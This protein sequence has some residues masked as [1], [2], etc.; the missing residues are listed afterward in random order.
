MAVARFGGAGSKSGARGGPF[1]L[2]D[3]VSYRAWRDAKLE[4]YPARVED[5]FVE[6]RDPA[7]P[8]ASERTAVAERCGRANAALYVFA[9]S[10]DERRL[11]SGLVAFGAAFGLTAIEDHRSA[12]A[13]GVVRIEVV[14]DGGRLGYIR[15]LTGSVRPP[16]RP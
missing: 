16:C 7:R 12:E 8:S 9:A 14:S 15:L 5:L 1:D 13:D 2:D 6:I 3:E 10:P 11:R 4:R